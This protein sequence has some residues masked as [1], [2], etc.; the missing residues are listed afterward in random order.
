MELREEYD[1]DDSS[2]VV[3]PGLDQLVVA[4][5]AVVVFDTLFSQI[6]FVLARL[7]RLTR[8]EVP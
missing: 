4:V 6:S 8:L 1:P 2:A 5:A 3:C 7:E